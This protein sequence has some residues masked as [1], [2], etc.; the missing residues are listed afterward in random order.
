MTRGANCN[1][2]NSGSHVLVYEVSSV[3]LSI[4][5]LSLLGAP[6]TASTRDALG[7]QL[8]ERCVPVAFPFLSFPRD[9]H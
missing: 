9:K 5:S 1:G 7:L 3:L 2:N 8:R 4:D 6:L